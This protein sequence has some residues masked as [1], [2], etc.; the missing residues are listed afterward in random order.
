MESKIKSETNDELKLTY[1]SRLLKATHEKVR[2]APIVL[3]VRE[4]IKEGKKKFC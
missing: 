3:G 1:I 2:V 4:I